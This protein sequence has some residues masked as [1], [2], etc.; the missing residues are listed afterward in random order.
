MGNQMSLFEYGRKTNWLKRK[1][2]KTNDSRQ[3]I[4]QKCNDWT[5]PTTLL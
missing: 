5:T 4:T 1:R 2:K 3:N